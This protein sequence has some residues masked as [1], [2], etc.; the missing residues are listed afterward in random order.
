MLPPLVGSGYE[1][2]PWL[3]A[4]LVPGV[5]AY[6]GFLA[7]TAFF[8]VRVETPEVLTIAS[9]ITLG[10]SLACMAALVPSLGAAGAAA[11][12][13]IG[14]VVGVAYL[15]R[16]FARIGGV[17]PWALVPSRAELADYAALA[18]MAARISGSN[19]YRQER[20]GV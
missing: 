20:A 2:V 8:G 11:A 15:V 14:A 3:L 4:L 6:G 10:S 12:T 1:D 18:R 19:A 9:V 5:V 17:S 16:A 7:L 13:S